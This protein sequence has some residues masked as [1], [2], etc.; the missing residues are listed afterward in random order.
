MATSQIIRFAA[1]RNPAGISLADQLNKFF[2]LN[3]ALTLVS[4]DV[5]W[6]DS[7]A[8]GAS[9]SVVLT[10]D[11]GLA[12]DPTEASAGGGRYLAVE[13]FGAGATS[14]AARANAFF[15]AN[16]G[17]AVRAVLLC[18]TGL[19]RYTD[20]E[21]LLVIYQAIQRSSDD[22]AAA[23]L[24]GKAGAN[25]AA[26]ATATVF[27]AI[28]SSRGYL[29]VTN[30]SAV[31]W[32]A[33]TG[34]LVFRSAGGAGL[35][36]IGPNC[37]TPGVGCTAPPD[38]PAPVAATPCPCNFRLVNLTLRTGDGIS[39]VSNL[40]PDYLTCG[41]GAFTDLGKARVSGWFDVVQDPTTHPQSVTSVSWGDPTYMAFAVQLQN[42][43]GFTLVA[44]LKAPGSAGFTDASWLMEFE[45]CD[46]GAVDITIGVPP[47]PPPPPPS[48]RCVYDWT[49]TWTGSAWVRSDPVVTT[50]MT[51]TGFDWTLVSPNVYSKRIVM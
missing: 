9:F 6:F 50:S 38:P 37:I 28:D 43:G 11:T 35:A 13:F 39:V 30:R 18:S 27:N 40:N 17:I 8:R 2:S 51:A 33:C 36:A 14:P 23:S 7:A 48:L 22:L 49:A 16:P 46:P 42:E 19:T 45:R 15:A 21:R 1:P 12:A 32:N 25:V 29:S 10:I 24:A 20:T 44:G 5:Q 3:T 34:A 31:Q 26:G 4:A 47:P 41:K